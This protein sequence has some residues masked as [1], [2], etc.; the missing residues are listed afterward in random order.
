MYLSQGGYASSVPLYVSQG[1]YNSGA[2]YFPHAGIV[3]SAMAMPVYMDPAY[4]QA[5]E[6]YRRMKMMKKISGSTITGNTPR[7]T[8][9]ISN[10]H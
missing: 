2:S 6:Q 1:G 9:M 10:L 3:H 8:P 4:M 5:A 7:L